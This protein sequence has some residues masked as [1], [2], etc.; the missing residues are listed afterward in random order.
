[1]GWAGRQGQAHEWCL[2]VL[3][4]WKNERESTRFRLAAWLTMDRLVPSSNRS[5]RQVAPCG[6]GS[7]RMT[8]CL[9]FRVFPRNYNDSDSVIQATRPGS[10]T[11]VL[12]VKP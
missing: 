6:V 12:V 3:P 7:Q 8:S 1:M 5:A 11:R 2:A 4:V 9:L 10:L